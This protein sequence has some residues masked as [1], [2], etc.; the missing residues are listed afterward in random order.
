MAWESDYVWVTGD[1][2]P[3]TKSQVNRA[4][5]RIRHAAERREDPSEDD[6][7]LLNVF[8]AWH[9]PVL[10]GLQLRLGSMI[11]G[12]NPALPPGTSIAGRPLKTRQA[13]I[14]KLVR[15]RSRLSRIQDVAGTR[16]VVP[17]LEHQERVLEH[18]L[19][20]FASESP[21]VKDTRAAGDELGY[22]ALHVVVT[23]DG[24]YAEIQLRTAA[25]ATW[26]QSVEILDEQEKSDLKHGVG[27]EDRLE[28]LKRLSDQLR[29]VDIGDATLGDSLIAVGLV[30]LIGY[31]ENRK[32]TT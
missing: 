12:L 27:P 20:E 18:I 31:I 5:E 2:F 15:E 24:R 26:A 9:S 21:A 22:R 1:E 7:H 11:A 17:T 23:L 29:R 10:N 8:R 13:I 3:F 28:F 19:T 32:G 30:G 6:L 4:G 25:Q 16:I 14:A